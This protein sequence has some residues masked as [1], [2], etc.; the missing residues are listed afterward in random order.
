MPLVTFVKQGITIEVPRGANLR[1]VALD[2][3]IDLYAFPHSLLNCR[4]RGLCGTC[5]VKVDDHRALSPRTLQDENK[6]SWE[7][8]NYRLAC[9]SQVLGDVEVVTNP[10]RAWGWMDHPTYERLRSEGV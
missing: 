10:R 1:Q 8:K 7:G 2:N 6:L 5:R 9:Q 4:G 3:K